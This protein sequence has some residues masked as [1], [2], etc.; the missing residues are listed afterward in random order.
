MQ[1]LIFSI[2]LSLLFSIVT[3]ANA[4]QGEL[5]AV[6]K[7][8]KYAGLVPLKHTK[9]DAEISGFLS[10]VNVTQE[11]ENNFNEKIEAIYVFPLPNNAAVD[12]M[13]MRIGERTIRGKIMKREEAREVYEAAKELF[14]GGVVKGW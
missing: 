4:T 13:T 8:G 11:F 7:D 3:L 9:V 12:Q 2:L 14:K 5:N 10:R 1:K 6:T